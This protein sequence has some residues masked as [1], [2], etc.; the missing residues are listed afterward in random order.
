MNHLE[1]EPATDRFRVDIETGQFSIESDRPLSHLSALA[2]DLT[3]EIDC[4][5]TARVSIRVVPA[6]GSEL[7]ALLMADGTDGPLTR[8]RLTSEGHRVFEVP[9]GVPLGLTW[10]PGRAAAHIPKGF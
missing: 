10:D 4:E 3:F 7:P 9:C 1:G 8:G 5:A 2:T 6:P